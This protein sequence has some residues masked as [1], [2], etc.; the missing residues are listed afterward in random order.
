MVSIMNHTPTGPP[1]GSR[2]DRDVDPHVGF[3]G[4][5]HALELLARRVLELRAE[6]LPLLGEVRGPRRGFAVKRRTMQRHA[7]GAHDRDALSAQTGDGARHEVHDAGDF[8]TA[9]GLGA[10]KLQDDRRG[11]LP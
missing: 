7:V 2:V 4:P 10:A 8:A 6:Q 3:A 1:R 9:E 5:D 11:G